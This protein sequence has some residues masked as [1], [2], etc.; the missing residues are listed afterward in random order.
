MRIVFD[1][2]IYISA[3]AIPGSSADNFGDIA[4]G[5]NGQVLVTFQDSTT[6]SGPGRIFVSLNATGGFGP[7]AF[8][9]PA[10]ILN[11]EHADRRRWVEEISTLHQRMR[12]ESPR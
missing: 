9:S 6:L 7:N 11:M 5:P 8:N 3:F 4:V 1:T 10:E 2:N 12:E